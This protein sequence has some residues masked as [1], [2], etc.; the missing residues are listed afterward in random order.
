M[1][2][3][4]ICPY[5]TNAFLSAN[6]SFWLHNVADYKQTG[7]YLYQVGNEGSKGK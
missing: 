6:V 7:I 4:Q 1:H 5:G 2:P 3:W